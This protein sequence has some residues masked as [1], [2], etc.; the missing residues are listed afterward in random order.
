MRI[1][2]SAGSDNLNADL[3]PRFGRAMY[4]LIVNDKGKL[5]K[6]IKNTGVRAMQGAGITAAQIVAQ[7]KVNA[8]ITGNIGPNAAMVL[9]S[10]EIKIF[11]ANP[12][13][14]VRDAFQQ[15]Q[16]GELKEV[17]RPAPCGPG[18]RRGLGQ[19]GRGSR[20]RNRRRKQ[21]PF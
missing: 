13:M 19:R 8:V 14:S 11:L 9:G 16:K 6:A 10:L 5:I 15:Y 18:F 12:T 7:E 3:D 17:T 20:H 1:C 21:N 2:I 4:F